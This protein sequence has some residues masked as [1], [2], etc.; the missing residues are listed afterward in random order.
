MVGQKQLIFLLLFTTAMSVH[1]MPAMRIDI[2]TIKQE[3]MQAREALLMQRYLYNGK[4]RRAKE[5]LRNQSREDG[6]NPTRDTQT[7]PYSMLENPRLPRRDKNREG[8]IMD[9]FGRVI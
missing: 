1:T 3:L 6:H 9:N 7:W 2:R 5:V 8:R 4:L